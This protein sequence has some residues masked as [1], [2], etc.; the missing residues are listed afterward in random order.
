MVDTEVRQII[1]R[2]VDTLAKKGIRIDQVVLYGSYASGNVHADSDI[3]IAII[4]P[5]FGKDRFEEG[6][7]LLQTA[8]RIDPR[9]QPVPI[10]SEAF[11]R[12]TWV[13]LLHE[14]KEKGIQIKAA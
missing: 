10:S 8:W 4:S 7:L 1:K 9:L 12:N 13:P 3:D 6:K 5:D 11:E 2:F 14:I